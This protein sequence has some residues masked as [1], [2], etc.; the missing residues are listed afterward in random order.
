MVARSK[1]IVIGILLIALFIRV[2]A[3]FVLRFENGKIRLESWE[4]ETIALNILEGNGFVYNDLET[5]YRAYC[6][7]LYVY[8]VTLIYHLF[9]KNHALLGFLQALISTC[10]CLVVYACGKKMFNKNVGVLA[11]ILTA[12]HPGLIVYT[13]K[14]HPLNMDVFLITVLLLLFVRLFYAKTIFLKDMVLAGLAAGFTLLARP[15]LIFFTAFA[16]LL[17]LFTKRVN[18]RNISILLV[19]T[20]L[21]GSTWCMRNYM[22]FKKTVFTRSGT[23]KVFWIGNNP[24]ASGGAM[25]PSGISVFDSAPDD[26]K[27]KILGKEEIE[28]NKIFRDEAWRFIIHQPA[29]ALAL[30]FKK[31]YYFFWFAPQTGVLYPGIELTV[32]KIFYAFI[33]FFGLYGL[34]IL[35]K[36][37]K[38]LTPIFIL[39]LFLVISIAFIQ[40]IFY[41]EARHRWAIEPV[42]LIFAA[43]GFL[44]L[45]AVFRNKWKINT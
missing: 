16:L 39:P 32:Y 31:G 14:I 23:G 13:T 27:N 42:I 6:E 33:A 37:G 5:P 41:V 18:A 43:S 26:F 3:L 22:L 17:L 28:Q 2:A 11:M 1:I 25:L 7:P 38:I 24:R 45:Y 21:I 29:R 10:L 20:F 19:C 15:T 30:F 12:M 36:T 34:A 9:G 8:F 44:R 35:I 40:S 4:Q